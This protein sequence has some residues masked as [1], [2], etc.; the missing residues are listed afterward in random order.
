MGIPIHILDLSDLFEQCIIHDFV[1]NYLDGRTPNPCCV[2]N[3]MIKFGRLLDWVREQGIPEMATGHYVQVRR[4]AL[5]RWEIARAADR[6]KDQAYYLCR[7]S[8]DQL[9]S[10]RTPLGGMTKIEVRRI[11]LGNA[12][13]VAQKSESQDICFIPDNDYR[14]FLASKL[15]CSEEHLAGPIVDVQGH[16][17]GNHSGI[18]NFT[19]GQRRGIRISS[20]EPLYVISLRPEEKAVVV[21]HAEDLMRSQLSAGDVKWVAIA[22]PSQPLRINAQIRYRHNAS[23]A[24]LY[25][26]SETRARILFDSPQRAITP[27]QAVVFFDES[28]EVVLGG[29]WI[30][31]Q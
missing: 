20:S 30:D 28:N 4:N 16:V 3:Q 2:C 18:H 26:L 23:P 8:Q 10:F 25:L 13:P 27:G 22:P 9:S 31:F 15:P 29:G 11:A 12:L 17:L 7:L 24:T 19:I 5:S 14:R 1:S 21:G 6:T